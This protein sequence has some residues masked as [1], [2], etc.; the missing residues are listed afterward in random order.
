M[1]IR[2][3][4]AVLRACDLLDALALEPDRPVS[5]SEL[6][7]AAVV[8]RATCDAILQALAEGGLVV[9]DEHLRYTLGPRCIA[10]G[11]AAR[12]ASPLL[13][14]AAIQAEALARRIGACVAVSVTDGEMT[15]VAEVA[16]HSPP[17][18]IS[19]RAGQSVA[20]HAPFGA[21]FVAWE[22][23]RR[24]ERWLD[25]PTLGPGA[26][27]GCLAALGDIRH[28]GFSVSVNDERRVLD[29]LDELTE[30]AVAVGVKPSIDSVFQE[31][32]G[33]HRLVAGLTDEMS[34]RINQLSA[35]VFDHDQRVV[36]ALLVLG[37]NTTMTGAEIQSLGETLLTAADRVTR[38]VG[39]RPHLLDPS[40]AGR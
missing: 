39:G 20:L 24:I 10:L 13:E 36:A 40:P 38:A 5:V 1:P 33:S 18:A 26:R 12:S 6:A 31:L 27:D 35:P 23:P 32:V 28:R 7:R 37:P 14:A 9:R 2:P 34:L 21:V 3:S 17:F 25:T 16:D 4:P 29:H 19:V 15:R 22:S 8:P 30:S 11:E